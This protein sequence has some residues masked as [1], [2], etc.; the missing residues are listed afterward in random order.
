MLSELSSADLEDFAA[1]LKAKNLKPGTINRILDTLRGAFVLFADELPKKTPKVPRL[2]EL[3]AREVFFE[4]A[5]F[6]AVLAHLNPVLRAP[7]VFAYCTGW[8][9][10]SEVLR[11]R[12]EH[13]DWEG[14]M[15]VLPAAMTKARR[16]RSFPFAVLPELHTL[17]TH[18]RAIT[19]GHIPWLFHRY[20]GKPIRHFRHAWRQAVSQA[21][22]ER[23]IPHDLRRTAARNLIRA[24][25]PEKVVMRLVG[26]ETSAMLQRY[27]IVR[28]DDLRDAVARLANAVKTIV[29][30]AIAPI[31]VVDQLGS[32]L[33]S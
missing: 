27:H 1:S 15:I 28:E 3:N 2:R 9:M 24:G 21:G 26:W 13:I 5:D 11:L 16:A 23:R 10:Q 32:L 29:T 8:R 25:V 31:A 19:P 12:W 4:R 22:L 6:D 33:V 30:R 17:I 18:Q 7:C 20:R 14:G